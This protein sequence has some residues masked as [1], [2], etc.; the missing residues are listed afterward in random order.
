MMSDF[1]LGK[2]LIGGSELFVKKDSFTTHAFVLG[3]TGSGKTGLI[4]SILEEAALNNIPAVVIDPKGD[5]V[6]RLLT[7]KNV[8]EQ[9]IAGLVPQER[10][11]GFIDSYQKGIAEWGIT[12]DKIEALTKRKV[13]V[14]T[15]GLSL[16]P[17]N[18]LERF[19]PPSSDDEEDAIQKSSSITLS[20]MS[21]LG[22]KSEDAARNPEGLLVSTIL[23]ELWK[24]KEPVALEKL[25]ETIIAPP[26]QKIGLLPLE[27]VISKEKRL[28]LAVSLNNLLSS[29]QLTYFRK[30]AELNFDSIFGNSSN[31]AIFTLAQLSDD[32]KQFFLG[33]LLSELYLWVRRQNGSDGLKMLLVFDEVYGFFPPYPQNPPTKAPV[34][35]LL[36]QA[37]AFGLGV[38]LSTQNPY[39]VDYKGLSNAGLW[40]LGRLQT[41]NDKERV[42]Q[43]LADVAGGEKVSSLLSQ[44]RQRE[45]ILHDV[46]KDNPVVFKTRQTVSLLVGPLSEPQLKNYVTAETKDAPKSKGKEL[47]VAPSGIEVK[48]AKGDK[49]F[50]S[51]FFE[52]ELPYKMTRNLVWQKKSFVSLFSDDGLEASLAKDFGEFSGE[53]ELSGIR[54]AGAEV[55]PLPEWA[56][57]LKKEAFE[58]EIKEALS[59][60]AELSLLKDKESGL[61]SEPSESREDFLKRAADER[62]KG[63]SK[64]K[65]Q[66]LSPLLK[67]KRSLEDEIDKRKLKAERDEADF[68]KRK[69]ETYANAGVSIL[70]GIF[71][72]RR[73]VLGGISSTMSKDRMADDAKQR[74]EEDN[75]LLQKAM[76][77]LTQI[78]RQIASAQADGITIDE[79]ELEVIKVLPYKSGI[80]VLSLA[81]VFK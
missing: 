79:S 64:Q 68:E 77:E 21:L 71:G 9:Q 50:P 45:F 36:K 18:I 47:I 80:R 65:D 39:D 53:A 20:L 76:D 13:K 73:S 67:K 1:F 29:P 22:R 25:L 14:F 38:I 69:T 11:S 48:Y 37:R 23:M 51:L 54:P 16:S 57:S 60:K 75:F 6:D 27:T 34:L 30:G 33:M 35:G 32:Q 43:G 7:F 26:F 52:S 41:D 74:F 49:L 3:M 12:S 19:S 40:F 72:S 4:V 78:D 5:L 56:A 62:A 70:R 31:E 8:D 46:R 42:A 17:V 58:R 44:V 59:L 55:F 66:E 63:V 2:E 15:P 10:R 24:S 28:A 61:V 81:I